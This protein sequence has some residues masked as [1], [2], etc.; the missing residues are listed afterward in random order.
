MLQTLNYIFSVCILVGFLIPLL[1]VVTGWFG[2]FFGG[3]PDVDLDI[4]TDAC[5]DLGVDL[6]VDA[7]VDIGVDVGTSAGAQTNVS[8]SAVI[9][10]NIMCLCLSLVVF[11]AIGHLTSRYMTNFLFTVLALL[12][13]F[14]AAA[15]SYVAL[16]KL[17]IEKLKRNDASAISF[18]ELRGKKAEVTLTIIPNSVGTISLR[19]STGAPISFRA[20]IDADFQG[21]MPDSIPKG[22]TVIITDVDN[23]HKLCYVCLPLN[24]L[25]EKEKIV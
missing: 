3:G 23:E 10:F 20:R 25:S 7:C 4:S 6:G 11:G 9:P 14:A 13:C 24:K 18:H 21:K 22:E 19:D 8:N 17:L 12:V 15:L 2:S 16:Y 1:N 5:A